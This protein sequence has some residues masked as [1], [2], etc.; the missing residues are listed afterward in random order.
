MKIEGLSRVQNRKH[1]HNLVQNTCV[2]LYIQF[3]GR[4]IQHPAVPNSFHG[5]TSGRQHLIVPL[6]IQLQTR[7]VSCVLA[8]QK[9]TH[10]LPLVETP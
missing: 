2:P 7:E 5:N 3:L 10:F 9:N 6:G 4:K 1:L 8:L